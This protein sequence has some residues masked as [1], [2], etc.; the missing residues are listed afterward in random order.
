MSSIRWL[1]R[2]IFGTY[3]V[4]SHLSAKVINSSKFNVLVTKSV[5]NSISLVRR[6]VETKPSLVNGDATQCSLGRH[7]AFVTRCGP[8]AIAAEQTS[9]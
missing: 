8:K 4:R 3:N 9:V 6:Q 7:L 2:T 1:L 5:T